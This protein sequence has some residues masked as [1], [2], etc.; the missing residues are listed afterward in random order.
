MSIVVIYVL[1][2]LAAFVYGFSSLFLKRSLEEGVGFMRTLFIAN[3]VGGVIFLPLLVLQE[4]PVVWGKLYLP[5]I[6]ACFFFMGQVT[7]FVAMRVGDISV[8]TPAL[9]VKVVFVALVGVLLFDLGI[10]PQGWVS[11]CLAAVAVALLGWQGRAGTTGSGG[12][13]RGLCYAVASAFFFA[14]CDNLVSAWAG[15]FGRPAFIIA[16][17]FLVALFSFVLMPYFNAPLRGIAWSGWKWVGPGATLM[18]LQALIFGTSLSYG[19]ATIANTIYSV[20]GLIGILLVLTVGPLF[21]NRERQLGRA[22][23][24]RRLLGSVVV[25]LAIVLMLSGGIEEG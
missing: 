6:A 14:V 17:F 8:L 3:W 9:G 2:V 7:T 25:L 24:A 16:M 23:I 11:V 10:T 12:V 20:R 1:P 4:A 22:V 21:G 19:N 15:D 18:G 13:M 5:L